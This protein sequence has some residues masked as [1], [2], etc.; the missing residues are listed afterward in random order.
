MAID[1]K[2]ALVLLGAGA[3]IEFGVP[4]TLKF[5]E[6]IEAGVLGDAWVQDQQGDKAYRTIKRR[7]K[8]YL[9]NPGI[10]H[11]EHIYHCAHELLHMRKP[12]VGAADEFRPI[13]A[14]F[15]RDTSGTSA[16]GLTALLGKMIEVI[17]TEVSSRCTAPACSTR[18]F[19]EF[20]E[21]VAAT[22]TTRIYTTNYD[23]FAL[24]A[25]PDLYT[26]YLPSGERETRFDED[27][28]WQRWERP[29]VFYLHGSVHM[30]Y[31]HNPG[32][33]RFADLMWFED[34]DEARKSAG[35][36]GSQLRRMDG[37]GVLRTPII[38]GLDKLSRI[39]QR[40]LP[41]FYAALTRDVMQAD[42]IYVI[43]AGLGDLHLN[44][45][46]EEARSRPDP[47]PLLFVDWWKG[48]F[49]ATHTRPDR[50]EIEMFHTLRIH[51]GGDAPPHSWQGGWKVSAGRTAAVWDGGFQAFLSKPA[52]HEAVLSALRHRR[53]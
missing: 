31:S 29:A 51:I 34:R 3:S 36:T 43:G 45:L 9:K 33:E 21:S 4:A 7:L 42:L 26:G 10:V 32:A 40:P 2:R 12:S 25:K 28:F 35:F 14:P 50:K 15:L 11:F 52:E 13:L 17:Y 24:Q 19:A 39:Q 27:G 41:Y 20:L 1:K 8:R 38:T 48:G 5:T 46:L 30:S 6:I 23:D 47:A 53:S 37:T 49:P 16:E 44:S 22:Y 18:P